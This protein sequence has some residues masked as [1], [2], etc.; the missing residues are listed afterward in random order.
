MNTRADKVAGE[1]LRAAQKLDR[2]AVGVAAGAVGPIESAVRTH[3]GVIGL[4]LWSGHFVP[5]SARY[6]VKTCNVP[7]R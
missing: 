4:H 2:E 5:G 7:S 6:I 1:Y 3:G